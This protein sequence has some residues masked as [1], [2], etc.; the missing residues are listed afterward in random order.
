MR[1]VRERLIAK[2]FTE[3]Q[4]GMAISEYEN[5]NVSVLRIELV[6]CLWGD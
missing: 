3:D 6:F 1:R 5:F 4:I 2:G